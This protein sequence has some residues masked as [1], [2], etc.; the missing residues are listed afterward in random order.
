MIAITTSRYPTQKTKA[1]CKYFKNIINFAELFTR[2]STKLSKIVKY[3]KDHKYKSLIV[4]HEYKG[5]PNGMLIK[6]FE[7]NIEIYFRM[8]KMEFIKLIQISKQLKNVKVVFIN[9]FSEN[10]RRIKILLNEIF[11]KG[12]SD[13]YDGLI[14]M[15]SYSNIILFRRYFKY[16]Y[17]KQNSFKF[18]EVTLFLIDRAKTHFE[19]KKTYSAAM[20]IFLNFNQNRVNTTV[21]SRIVRNHCIS[22]PCFI[23]S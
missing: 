22:H 21:E 14:L 15:K 5:N 19:Y 8:I 11:D 10:M 18:V 7:L 16:Y 17:H 23:T 9:F 2:G 4:L 12:T 6:Y 1:L 13:N 20:K 3:C